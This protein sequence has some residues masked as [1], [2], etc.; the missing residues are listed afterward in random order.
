MGLTLGGEPR[1]RCAPGTVLVGGVLRR[2]DEVTE[3]ELEAA[4]TPPAEP[5]PEP[6][7]VADEVPVVE[8]EPRPH[9]KCVLDDALRTITE[10]AELQRALAVITERAL[11][12]A[13]VEINHMRREAAALE[14]QQ[15][16]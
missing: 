4:A 3:A 13:R 5:A 10:A 14:N 2:S 16:K 15:E 8:E 12:T 6:D 9:G 7:D 11:R 1:R